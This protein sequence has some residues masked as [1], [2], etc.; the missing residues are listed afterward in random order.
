MATS[1]TERRLPV[2]AFPEHLRFN[3]R[4]QRLILTI[5]NPY[6]FILRFQSEITDLFINIGVKLFIVIDCSLMQ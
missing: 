6:D 1:R 5:Y 4:N 2:F 3:E